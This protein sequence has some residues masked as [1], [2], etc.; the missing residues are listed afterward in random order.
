MISL[1]CNA[2]KQASKH[3]YK[4]LRNDT[5]TVVKIVRKIAPCVTTKKDTLKYVDVVEIIDTINRLDTITVQ[6]PDSAGVKVFRSIVKKYYDI[7][8]TKKVTDTYY[9][10]L[11]K[12][13]MAFEIENRKLT[14]ERDLQKEKK[15]RANKIIL[16][17]FI[18]LLLSVL[19]N[20]LQYKKIKI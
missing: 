5:A 17:I 20:V 3:T 1:S 2:T 19:G 6:C 16:W 8:T 10:T 9:I 18:F 4:A 11:T 12:K 13:D 14:E 7:I 15:E